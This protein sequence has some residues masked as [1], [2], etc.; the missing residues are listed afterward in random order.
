[1]GL[2]TKWGSWGVL[3][4]RDQNPDDSPKWKAI[5]DFTGKK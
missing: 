4:H 1:M 5:H 2:Y 3:E